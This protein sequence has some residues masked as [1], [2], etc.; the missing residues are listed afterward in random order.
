MLKIPVRGV[1]LDLNSYSGEG[2]LF[3]AKRLRPTEE[4]RFNKT[5]A[6]QLLSM[7]QLPKSKTTSLQRY[8]NL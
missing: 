3:S 1:R 6:Q 2:G 8:Q 7:L 4:S 5:A